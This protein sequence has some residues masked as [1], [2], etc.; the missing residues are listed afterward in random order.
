MSLWVRLGL[1]PPP[2]TEAERE[3]LALRADLDARLEAARVRL[4]AAESLA[5]SASRDALLLCRAL[6][7]DLAALLPALVEEGGG[8]GDAGL[9][10]RI[11][12]LAARLEE[13]EDDS[14]SAARAA[15]DLRAI[16]RDLVRRNDALKR[17]AL[18][19][20][21]DTWRRRT[22]IRIGAAV[23]IAALAV[24]ATATVLR[25]ASARSDAAAA[26][27]E[28]EFA[29]GTAA[30]NA[31][32]LAGAADRFS[33]AVAALPDDR[34]SADAYNSLGWSLY[35]LGRYD[36]AIAAYQKSVALDPAAE[37]PRNN[38]DLAKR[39]RDATRR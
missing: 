3:A 36:E 23:G 1:L 35:K 15:R 30:L 34:R 16:L 13:A 10:R 28:R 14:A 37:R 26:Q 27:L 20:R 32:D 31:G 7:R 12:E 17:T 29:A 8:A 33:R 2:P 24:V 38:L 22:R 19:T 11:D 21:L 9:T 18:R 5:P 4:E 25:H 39:D 6:R